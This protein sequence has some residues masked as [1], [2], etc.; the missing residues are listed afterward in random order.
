MIRKNMIWKKNLDK[1]LVDKVI[2]TVIGCKRG[3]YFDIRIVESDSHWTNGFTIHFLSPMIPKET[4][5]KI[6]DYFIKNNTGM[7]NDF[8]YYKVT[9]TRTIVLHRTNVDDI[10]GTNVKIILY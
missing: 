2:K 8:I 5:N 1:V 7:D 10:R 9:P 3:R 6:V 4:A